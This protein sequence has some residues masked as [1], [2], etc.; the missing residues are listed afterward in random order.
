MWPVGRR[1]PRET[2]KSQ[3]PLQQNDVLRL[4]AGRDAGDPSQEL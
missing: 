4:A 1:F 2:E 3:A